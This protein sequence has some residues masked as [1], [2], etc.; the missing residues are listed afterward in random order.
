MLSSNPRPGHRVYDLADVLSGL[1]SEARQIHHAVVPGAVQFSV[2][3]LWILEPPPASV[4]GPALAIKRTFQPSTVRLKRKH[5]FLARL[6][7][8][9]GRKTLKR[10][11]L[12]GRKRLSM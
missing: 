5:G 10:R 9:G 12:K 3:W 11:M 6:E 2:D 1:V 4:R 7:S 8:K